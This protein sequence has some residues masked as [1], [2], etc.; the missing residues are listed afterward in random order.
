MA[1]KH[2]KNTELKPTADNVAQDLHNFINTQT[3]LSVG[4]EIEAEADISE[5][6]VQ[7]TGFYDGVEF[8]FSVDME[9]DLTDLYQIQKNLYD[10][11]KSW[12]KKLKKN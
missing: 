5:R 3:N 11:C 8:S 1:K 9:R 2:W 12:N 7:M 4:W 10:Y 6:W